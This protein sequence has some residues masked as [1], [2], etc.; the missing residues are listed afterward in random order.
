MSGFDT[1]GFTWPGGPEYV[2][3][4]V[5][6]C[7]Q[8]GGFLPGTP[9]RREP[10]EEAI[11][12]DGTATES[13]ET[14]T[15]ELAAILGPIEYRVWWSACGSDGGPHTAHREVMAAGERHIYV[16]TKCGHE[17]VDEGL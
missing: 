9:V 10:W 1:Y 14:A 6:R 4:P 3:P 7:A 15:G 2:P 12:C 11:D 5:P 13:M 8:C 16:C 17:N